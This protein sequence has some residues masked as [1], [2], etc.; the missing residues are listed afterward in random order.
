M[1]VYDP[2]RSTG[3]AVILG[4]R[5]GSAVIALVDALRAWNS[6]RVTRNALVR[7]SDRELDDIGLTRGE[8]GSISH[9]LL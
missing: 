6:M 7:L 8:I 3:F 4:Y 2:H 5:V 9:R 1:T